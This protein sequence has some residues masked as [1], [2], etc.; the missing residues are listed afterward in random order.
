MTNTN[1]QSPW[2]S[3]TDTPPPKDCRIEIYT[4]QRERYIGAWTRTTTEDGGF[5]IRHTNEWD[6]Y[7]IDLDRVTHWKPLAPAPKEID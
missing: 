4:K 5:L 7:I 2:R 3:V 6:Y 1:S